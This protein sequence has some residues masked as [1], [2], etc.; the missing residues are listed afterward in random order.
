MRHLNPREQAGQAW[1]ALNDRFCEV[2]IVIMSGTKGKSKGVVVLLALSSDTIHQPAYAHKQNQ[3]R[4]DKE[5]T[6]EQV[7]VLQKR[8]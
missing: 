6:I 4:K 5:N 1:E 3:H 8:R 7:E 2:T